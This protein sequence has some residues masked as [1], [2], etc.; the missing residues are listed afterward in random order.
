MARAGILLNLAA[1]LVIVRANYYLV[2]VVFGVEPG[3]ILD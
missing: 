2:L 1:I 3:V